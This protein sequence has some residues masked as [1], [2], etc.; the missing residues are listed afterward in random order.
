MFKEENKKNRNTYFRKSYSTIQNWGGL[1]SGCWWSPRWKCRW[2]ACLESPCL[3][4]HL[5][6]TSPQVQEHH[7][8]TGKTPCKS[9]SQR[10][11]L[12]SW[13]KHRTGFNILV[14]SKQMWWL[15][16]A[17]TSPKCW[18]SICNFFHCEKR[19]PC[20][21]ITQSSLY[22]NPTTLVFLYQN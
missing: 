16:S 6:W 8:L 18:C 15:C 14:C 10:L 9:N 1:P 22:H 4:I 11:S 13:G 3:N 5:Y 2:R 17:D 21:E 19:P 12:F 20:Q 7:K